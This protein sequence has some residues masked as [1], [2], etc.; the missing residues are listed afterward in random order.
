VTATGQAAAAVL[1]AAR[2]AT[3]LTPWTSTDGRKW[4]VTFRPLLPGE[5]GCADLPG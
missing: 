2:S 1:A 4:S 3:Q 5:S